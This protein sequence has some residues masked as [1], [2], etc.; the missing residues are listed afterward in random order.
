MIGP[1][2]RRFRNESARTNAFRSE[3]RDHKAIGRSYRIVGRSDHLPLAQLATI[4]MV[5]VPMIDGLR[6][7]GWRVPLEADLL[8]AVVQRDDKV[9][10]Q[11]ERGAEQSYDK[12]RHIQQDADGTEAH[13]R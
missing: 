7:G 6:R 12:C 4:R 5:P 8:E 10:Q 13:D 9:S 2:D 11:A 3:N 1:G